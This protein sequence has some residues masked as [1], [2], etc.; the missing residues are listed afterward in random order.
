MQSGFVR[1]QLSWA[2]WSL[3]CT[4]SVPARPEVRWT[5]HCRKHW[6]NQV[7]WYYSLRIGGK[8]S[9]FGMC[10]LAD[11]P[12]GLPG[13]CPIIRELEGRCACSSQVKLPEGVAEG[14]VS[15][16]TNWKLKKCVK[17][18]EGKKNKNHQTI[19]EKRI[20]RV[21]PNYIC[22]WIPC[23]FVHQDKARDYK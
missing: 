7:S 15:I 8:I 5:E 2:D 1:A 9:F 10:Q 6:G 22:V 17:F 20:L 11:L 3:L 12:P 19:K 4:S 18:P 14:L 21:I 13:P 23:N 16:W